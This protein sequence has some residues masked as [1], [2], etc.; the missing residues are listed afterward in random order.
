MNPGHHRRS[1]RL[2]G[3]DYTQPGAYFITIVTHQR[4]EIFGQVVEG[5]ME[6]SP[7]GEIAREEWFRTA[8]LRPYV[9]LFEDEF[10]V[11]PNHVHGIVWITTSTVRAERRSAPTKQ[12]HIDAGS[13]GAI[14]RA[15]KSA[16]T[17]AI[18]AAENTR[19]RMI[20]Q[21]NYY[22]HIIRSEADFN[23]IW[24]YIDHN[25]QKWKEDQL[26]PSP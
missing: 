20:C 25:P 12:P 5:E 13:L 23:S 16:V 6:L 24:R 8:Q 7:L 11:M 9:N 4:R 21:R 22:E 15:Y 26:H 3:Y 2:E 18:N 19:G 1:I 10:V 17:Y 14:V